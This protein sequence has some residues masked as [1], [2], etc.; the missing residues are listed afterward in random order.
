MPEQNLN[1]CLRVTLIVGR[2][3]FKFLE[4]GILPNEIL[5]RIFQAVQYFLQGR[6]IG[7]RLDIEDHFVLHSKLLGDRQGVDRGSSV[8][9][10]INTDLCHPAAVK[11][12]SPFVNP[13]PH[14]PIRPRRK[15]D[16]WAFMAESQPDEP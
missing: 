4:F 3:E 10:M 12:L 1:H 13:L 6:T 8:G 11:P 5:Y 15:M 16:K 9:I 7:R 14:P 2:I